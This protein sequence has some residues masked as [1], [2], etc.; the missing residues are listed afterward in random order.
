MKPKTYKLSL[1][2]SPLEAQAVAQMVEAEDG[3]WINLSEHL[4]E[5]KEL[6]EQLAA[7]RSEAASWQEEYHS[8]NA[9]LKKLFDNRSTNA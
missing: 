6:K 1:R 3:G 8:A 7:A 5:I 9:M 4:A 2:F